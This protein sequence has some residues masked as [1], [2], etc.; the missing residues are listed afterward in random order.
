MLLNK[1]YNWKKNKHNKIKYN[2]INNIIKYFKY[3]NIFK[4]IEFSLT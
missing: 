4:K 1:K 3:I 2:K